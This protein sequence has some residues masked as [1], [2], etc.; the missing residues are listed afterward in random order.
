MD[1]LDAMLEELPRH[2]VPDAAL[3]EVMA[4]IAAERRS[5]AEQP[6]AMG[7]R[8]AARPTPWGQRRLVWVAGVGVA[9][10]VALSAGLGLFASPAAEQAPPAMTSKGPGFAA[11]TTTSIQLGVGLLR[12]HVPVALGADA[13]ARP[14]DA[15][16]LR[17]TTDQE[18]F[19]YVLRVDPTGALEVVHGT[20]TLP[21]THHVTVGGQIVGYP[22]ADLAGAQRFA[23]AWSHDPWPASE[24]LGQA[25]E[26]PAGLAEALRADGA[27]PRTLRGP[28]A[29]IVADARDIVVDGV[30]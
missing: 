19:A 1:R 30:R 26:A 11:R 7:T 16:L 14:S 22:L 4:R 24:T 10:S 29:G 2:D 17:Y 6:E 3:D 15:V 18:G 12:D 9:A 21:G 13:T 28:L 8:P 27:F 23:V 25:A 20:P 5:G